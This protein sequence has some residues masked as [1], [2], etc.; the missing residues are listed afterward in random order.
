MSLGRCSK[1][2]TRE[3]H[4][5]R[6]ESRIHTTS[7]SPVGVTIKVPKQTDFV[8][9]GVRLICQGRTHCD[10]DQDSNMTHWEQDIIPEYLHHTYWWAY[11]HPQAVRFWERQWLVNLIL[12]GNFNAL[13]EEALRH[14]QDHFLNGE[15]GTKNILQIAC[16]YGNLSEHLVS[17]ILLN[18]NNK[19]QSTSDSKYNYHIVDIAPIQLKNTFEKLAYRIERLNPKTL[20]VN[21]NDYNRSSVDILL[22]QQNSSQLSFETGSMDCVL[23]FFLLHE[24]PL[25]V[26]VKTLNEAIRVMKDELIIVDYHQPVHRLNPWK[27][28][29]KQV[30]TRL[31]PFAM[32]LW[33]HDISQWIDPHYRS[34]VHIAEKKLYFDGLYQKVVIRKIEQKDTSDHSTA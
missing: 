7:L 26:R 22:D 25:D 4:C 11:L 32:D 8:D 24:Q 9:A 19:Q 3:L 12:W 28:F 16:V 34:Q 29:M 10:P 20:T 27:Y 17:K 31:E 6:Q 30:L 13:R 14:V 21:K 1:V 15:S 2:V 33:N 23:L 5:K 18:R